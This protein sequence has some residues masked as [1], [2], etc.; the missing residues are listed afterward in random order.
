MAESVRSRLNTQKTNCRWIQTSQRYSLRSNGRRMGP[1]F[2]PC[3]SD[4]ARLHPP[5]GMVSCCVSYLRCGSRDGMHRSRSEAWK[6][7]CHPGP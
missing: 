5:R 6:A 1:A 3:F 4:P 7:P 2:L